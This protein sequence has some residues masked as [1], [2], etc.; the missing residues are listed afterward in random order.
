MSAPIDDIDPVHVYSAENLI[1]QA[2]TVEAVQGYKQLS[3]YVEDDGTL[4]KA[5]TKTLATFYLSP[6]GGT[7][8]DHELNLVL[9]SAKFDKYKGFGKS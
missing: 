7:L 9:Y 1:R 5:A 3:F 8:R 6:S 4:A 2:E